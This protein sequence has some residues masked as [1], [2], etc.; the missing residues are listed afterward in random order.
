MVQAITV[1]Q[2]NIALTRKQFSE[3]LIAAL[4]DFSEM[5]V[6]HEAFVSVFTHYHNPHKEFDSSRLFHNEFKKA[7][8]TD[9]A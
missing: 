2:H 8:E 4:V 1:D 3:Q 5:P 6:K 9:V 7:L